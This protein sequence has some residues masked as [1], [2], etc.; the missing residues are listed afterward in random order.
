[1]FLKLTTTRMFKK[2]IGRTSERN[3]ERKDKTIIKAKGKFYILYWKILYYYRY[4][5]D[6]C[7]IIVFRSPNTHTWNYS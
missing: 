6:G 2:Q 1:M 5:C 3:A 7:V 4:I